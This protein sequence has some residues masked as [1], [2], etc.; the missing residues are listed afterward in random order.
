MPSLEMVVILPAAAP[1]VISPACHVVCVHWKQKGRF[2]GTGS[3]QLELRGNHP[4]LPKLPI[5]E[6]H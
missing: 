2:L 5:S 3:R 4:Q 6:R 1:P